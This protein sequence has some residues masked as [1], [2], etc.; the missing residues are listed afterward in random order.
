MQS[1]IE[2]VVETLVKSENDISTLLFVLPSKRAGTFL[3]NSIAKALHKTTFAPEIYSIETFVEKIS[4]FS[5]AS[6][7]DQLFTLYQSYLATTK[8]ASKDSFLSF[9][10]WGQTILQDFNEIDR[11]LVDTNKIFSHMSAIQE[12]NTYMQSEK[13]P[14]IQ[15]YI[16]FWN[17][18]D[19]LYHHFNKSLAEKKIAT[20]G[21]AYRKA[22][23]NIKNFVSSLKEQKIIFIGFNA[24][25]KAEEFI[26]QEIL[27]TTTSDIYWDIDSYFLED[28]LHDASYF[29]RQH[30]KTWSY[31][32]DH[33][34]NGI[35]NHYLGQKNIQIIGVP[36]N[37][38]QA[39]YVG[40]LLK[41]IQVEN[42]TLLKN[43]A[44]VL[45]DEHLL[46]PVMNAIPVEIDRIN[47]TMGYPISKTPLAGLFSLY[48]DLWLGKTKNGWFYEYVLNI[49]S[50]PYIQYFLEENTSSQAMLIANTI[51]TKNWSYIKSQQLYNLVE[52]PKLVSILFSEKDFSVDVFLNHCLKIITVLKEKF[53]AL[54]KPLELEYLYR[55]NALFN[56]ILQLAEQHTFLADLKSLQSL[57]KELLATETLDFQGEPLQGTQIMGMLESRNLDFETVII[58]SV[59]EGIL[60]SGK[61]NNSFIP[62]DIKVNYGL[63]TYKEKDAVYTYHFYRLLQR[64]KN[65]YLIYNT[66]PNVLEGNEKSRLLTQLLTDENRN[67]AIT[68]ITAS[69]LVKTSPV[70][71]QSISKNDTLM[72]EIKALGTRGFSPSSLSNYIRN[73]IDFYKKSILKI[74]DTNEVEESVAANTFGTIVHDSLE[75]L[76]QNFV[77][78][79]LEKES[80]TK[81]LGEVEKTVQLNFKK[82]Y[83]EGEIS[84]GKNLIAYHVIL[85]YIQNFIQLEIKEVAKHNIK[86]LALEQN[87]ELVF[88][89]PNIEG[90]IKIKGKLDRIDEVDGVL[91]IIDYKTGKVEPKNVKI[92]DWEDIIL[93]YDMSKAFQLMCYA[94]LY[95]QKT[96]ITRIEAGI[97][98]F[99]NLSKGV[100]LF[101]QNNTTVITEDTLKDFK[102]VLFKLIQEIFDP[103]VPFTEKDI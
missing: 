36:K 81:L 66:E 63:P 31:F 55:F 34:L 83:A 73:P 92:K 95:D 85:R 29:I 75:D 87:L 88:S 27:K 10:K 99:K 72:S 103:S 90:S 93:N 33:P 98:S 45:G 6:S 32:G 2:E 20:Q 62:F 68:E 50:N 51:K 28:S 48:F 76:Y 82:T 41:K 59:N 46:N 94:L 44:V 57:Y 18:L 79:F 60:P 43:T 24:L 16:K 40:H 15:D 1:F 22:S 4:G 38:S 42:S 47:I 11:Y 101:N 56:Q 26:I 49:L 65:V 77:G 100:L 78:K 35:S 30:K 13:T 58:S 14:M 74:Y 8:S 21:F 84:T 54:N 64:A 91:R 52:D 70:K 71:K 3:K 67:A 102:N 61:S 9:S 53:Q 96:P 12:M 5:Y 69:S 17:S 25:N 19:A 86:V 23:E 7:T 89:V 80:L 39:N 37:I 97:L